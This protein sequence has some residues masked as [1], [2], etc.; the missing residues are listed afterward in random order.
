MLISVFAPAP[1]VPAV[2][3]LMNVD[4]DRRTP[5]LPR[6]MPVNLTADEIRA[7]VRDVLG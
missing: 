3:F 2:S 7:L 1:K 6:P 5:V 4:P